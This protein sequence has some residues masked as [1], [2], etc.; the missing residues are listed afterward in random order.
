MSTPTSAATVRR[1]PKDRK[2]Q[3]NESARRLFAEHG[4][5]NVSMAQIADDVGITAGALYRHFSN[6]S[7]L[8]DEVISGAVDE[9]A[10]SVDPANTL[11]ERFAFAVGGVVARR[12]LGAL[13]WRESRHLDPAALARISDRLLTAVRELAARLRME[14]PSLS[15]VQAEELATAV[16]SILAS[17]SFHKTSLAPPEFTALLIGACHAVCAADL[18]ERR[19]IPE[20]ARPR[21]EPASKRERLLG[22]AA[23]LFG[24]RGFEATALGDIGAAAGVT[25]PNLY[26][27]FG[28]KADILAA[29]TERGVSALWLVL[30]AALRE[31]D[32]PGAALRDLVRG[33]VGLMMDGTI[34]AAALLTDQGTVDSDIRARE[35]EYVAEWVVLLR[36]ARPELDERPARVLVHTALAVIHVMGSNPGLR[37]D[38][39]LPENLVVLANAVLHSVTPPL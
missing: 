1:R 28:S 12:D 4:Y 23:E 22:H 19:P 6:K 36:G 34:M 17:T 32:E 14:R 20:P 15:E 13:W 5:P 8:L 11:D 30:H 2:A 27:Y 35:R 33:Y 16:H 37:A 24:S 3:I 25:G 39:A 26:G 18:A 29:A 31:N 38:A 9:L 10:L 21:L 7:V